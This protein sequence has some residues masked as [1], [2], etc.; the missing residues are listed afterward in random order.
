[1]VNNFEPNEDHKQ[2]QLSFL[3]HLEVLRW[4]LM[5][6]VIVVCVLAV[7]VFIYR[8]FV[9][10]D[11]IFASQSMDIELSFAPRIIAISYKVEKIDAN[12]IQSF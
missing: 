7:V 11:I 2:N 8:D 5:R 10:T 9:M 4:I 12:E 1:M 6:I 3:E